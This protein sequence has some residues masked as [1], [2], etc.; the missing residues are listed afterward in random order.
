MSN[1]NDSQVSTRKSSKSRISRSNFTAVGVA[2]GSVHVK[3]RVHEI[4]GGSISS[5]DVDRSK[6]GVSHRQRLNRSFVHRLLNV[7]SFSDYEAFKKS[8]V[9]PELKRKYQSQSP[10]EPVGIKPATPD[11]GPA[12]ARPKK[13]RLD[14]RNQESS[15]TERVQSP[16]IEIRRKSS[17]RP[18]P[19]FLV[20]KRT[21]EYVLDYM[22]DEQRFFSEDALLEERADIELTR[23]I[24]QADNLS[25][26]MELREYIS[27]TILGMLPNLSLAA[28]SRGDQESAIILNTGEPSNE[29]ANKIL[30]RFRSNPNLIT[31][32]LE[33]ISKDIREFAKVG[34]VSGEWGRL[35]YRRDTGEAVVIPS[36]E[37][38]QANLKAQNAAP[39]SVFVQL[40]TQ[41]DL[42]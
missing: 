33:E 10:V 20:S 23:M 18:N 19:D 24:D 4:K 11:I 12:P 7:P 34:G 31:P 2:A 27:R 40:L 36:N 17:D 26:L 5:F 29:F 37:I 6:G 41:E 22:K 16:N 15:S 32:F 21:A 39:P 42:E 28:V 38:I 35:L 9:K 3:V 14:N 8:I 13:I 25:L 30:T 1:S